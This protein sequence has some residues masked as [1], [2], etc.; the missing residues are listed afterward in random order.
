MKD[1]AS[2]LTQLRRQLHRYPEASGKEIRTAEQ[3]KAYLAQYHPDKILSGLGGHG[4]AAIFD[5][6]QPGPSVMFRCELDG[7]PIEELNDLP[8]RSVH[9]GFGHMCGHDGHM[10]IVAGLASF[11]SRKRPLKGRVILL[12]QPSEENGKGAELVIRDTGFSA[13]RP[14]YVFAL[15]NLPGFEKHEVIIKYPVFAAASKGLSVFLKGKSS[16]AAEPE[17][18]RNPSV[19]VS[20]VISK[21]DGLLKAK[22]LFK[23]FTLI[24]PIHLRVGRLAFG[25]SPGEGEMHFTLRSFSDEDMNT[26][27]GQVLQI[28]KDT[29][30]EEQINCMVNFHEE[31]PTTRNAREPLEL[32]SRVAERNN[33]KQNRIDKP[34]KWSEDFGHFTELFKGA[35]FGLG[36]GIGTPALHNPA[37]DFPDELT[38]TGVKIFKGIYEELLN[39][40]L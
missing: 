9:Q 3:I 40:S 31:F 7:L 10:G 18:G 17:N 15:H 37:F 6:N 28:I 23:D 30:Q 1:L 21:S 32:I 2:E 11:L 14:D 12:F 13:I 27:S 16:H 35:I 33:L 24:T 26:L 20:R 25:T 22:D 34:F 36:S 29:C 8:Y 5:G 38:M 4:V 39:A 19:L